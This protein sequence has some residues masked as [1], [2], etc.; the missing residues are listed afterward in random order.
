MTAP[1]DRLR[2][3][4]RR[5]ADQA[6]RGTAL[7]EQ[8]IAAA[9]RTAG[10]EPRRGFPTWTMP[11]LAAAS[12]AA[13]VA[14]VF[15]AV[16]QLR[17]PSPEQPGLGA[18]H[19]RRYAS[20]GPTVSSP[21]Q[22]TIG[23]SRTA[24]ASPTTSPPVG[25]PDNAVGLANFAVTDIT[26][27][28]AE[29]AWAIGTADCL[30]GSA[31]PCGAMVRTTDGGANW[32]SMTQPPGGV[33]GV[34]FAT[35]D[36]GYAYSADVLEMT[37]D[38]GQTWQRQDGGAVALESLDGNVVRVTSSGSGCPGPCNL[39]VQFAEIGSTTWTASKLPVAADAFVADV[40]LVRS[41]ADAYVLVTGDPAGG[42]GKAT[43]TLLASHDDGATWTDRG[44]PC[45]QRD[46]ELDSTAVSAAPGSVTV[47]CLLRGQ[48]AHLVATSRDNGVSFHY[49]GSS[50]PL[51]SGDF[52]AGDPTSV[53]AV[54]GRRS[55][56]STDGGDSW[57]DTVVDGTATFVGFESETLGRV[58]TD[59]GRT[60]WTTTD[61]G[62]SWTAFTFP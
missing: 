30:D 42:G 32:K 51:D 60:I 4:L 18:S 19:P 53:V 22:T 29:D 47:L 52:I 17:S 24:G 20:V 5:R 12:V 27:Y 6:P 41:D 54:G 39:G 44:E 34:R 56:V 59:A 43:S 9:Q 10:R 26:F 28:G 7:A 25:P 31:G 37:T 38:G 23:A 46:G 61:A 14:G 33:T 1:E 36:V 13:I 50:V 49:A 3:E 2:E 35:R 40:Q 11:L 45:P 21:P 62:T 48:A 16:A 55:Y 58:V 8:I 15:V 57:S